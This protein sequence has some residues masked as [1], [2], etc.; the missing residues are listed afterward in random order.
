VSPDHG[1]STGGGEI[2]II[3]DNFF[4]D[5]AA[6]F[7]TVP[8]TNV[9]WI[10]R[11]KVTAIL[12]AAP[13]IRGPV[14][15]TV[16]NTDGQ[17]VTLPK[18]FS[19]YPGTLGFRAPT[20]NAACNGPV[21]IAARDINGDS[22]LDLVVACGQDHTIASL[23]GNGDGSFQAPIKLAISAAPI[24]LVVAEFDGDS[25]LDLAVG[26]TDSMASGLVVLRG[27]GDGTFQVLGHYS[28]GGSDSVDVGDFN[29]DGKLDVVSANPMTCTIF[30][31]AGDGTFG[32]TQTLNAVGGA[33]AV[34]DFRS[35]GR[36]D[37]VVQSQ[38]NTKQVVRYDS[39]GDGTFATPQ[40]YGTTAAPFWIAA[41]DLDGDGAPDV[42]TANEDGTADVLLSSVFRF[43]PAVAYKTDGISRFVQ[44]A[45]LNTDSVPDVVVANGSFPFIPFVP[46]GTD[47]ITVLLGKGDGTLLP[48]MNLAVGMLPQGVAVGDFDGDGLPDIATAATNGVQ[49]SI[50]SSQ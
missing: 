32:L 17:S 27:M 36:S 9:G 47:D 43:K 5:I 3:G 40:S 2:T 34:A 30:Q 39:N 20:G 15:V 25:K 38:T 49:I 50:N 44:V 41:V 19:Y 24:A 23:L 14:S 45:D 21:A 12:P 6:Q 13:G 46:P 48:G 26:T 10:S 33:V 16:T 35:I 42:V 28:T 22:K 8:A 29:L 31:G 11:T 7:G 1:P 37:I 4:P 18:A